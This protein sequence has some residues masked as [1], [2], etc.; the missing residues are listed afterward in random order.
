[1]VEIPVRVDILAQR[2]EKQPE[3]DRL[4]IVS[5][6]QP[7][8]TARRHLRALLGAERPRQAPQKTNQPRIC[9][10]NPGGKKEPVPHLAA[11]SVQDNRIDKQRRRRKHAK[12]CHTDSGNPAHAA[13]AKRFLRKPFI[14]L[15][16]QHQEQQINHRCP[17]CDQHIIQKNLKDRQRS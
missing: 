14:I 4:D 10:S 13:H 7:H 16:Y 3:A 8:D 2:V 12:H 15:L 11:K 17:C 5:P 9:G 1:M 6:R